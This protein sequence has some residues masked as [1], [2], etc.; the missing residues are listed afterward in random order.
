MK[1]SETLLVL[2]DVADP[3]YAGPG[4]LEVD[5][6]FQPIVDL[7]AMCVVRPLAERL[8]KAGCR[9]AHA[10]AAPEKPKA[11]V[12]HPVY[13]DPVFSA[14][15]PLPDAVDLSAFRTILFAGYFANMCVLHRAAGVLETRRRFAGDVVMIADATL[16]Y[17]AHGDHT[18]ARLAALETAR[19]AGA[20]TLTVQEVLR[21]VAAA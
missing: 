6:A 7:H 8:R 15:I 18:R 11:A 17:D 3:W 9:I 14:E 20:R 13:G 19:Q 1:A 21:N 12:F 16:G 5:F 2:I 10:R 4:M